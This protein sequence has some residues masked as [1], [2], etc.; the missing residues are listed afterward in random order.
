MPPRL[1]TVGDMEKSRLF[2]LQQHWLFLVYNLSQFTP[3]QPFQVSLVFQGLYKHIHSSSF[4][5]SH[6]YQAILT[7]HLNSRIAGVL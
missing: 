1:D 4:P 2:L 6:E 7:T 5:R 3:G